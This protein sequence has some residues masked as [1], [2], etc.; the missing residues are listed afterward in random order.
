MEFTRKNKTY[1]RM[2]MV[3]YY[4]YSFVVFHFLITLHVNV[5]RIIPAEMGYLTELKLLDLNGNSLQG[6][7]P[8][9][10]FRKLKK[11]KYL[12]LHMNDLFGAIPRDIGLLKNLKELTLFGN[13]FFGKIPTEIANL[14]KL[15]NLDLYAN[16]LTGSIPSDIGKLK[17][18]S[19]YKKFSLSIHI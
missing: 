11:L 10:I 19:K 6:V 3:L 1:L 5:Y 13:F 2:S 9:L 14:K 4:V 18:L 15:Q 8:T 7:L 16:N 17:N 12:N